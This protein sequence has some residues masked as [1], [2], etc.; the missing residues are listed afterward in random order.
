MK[1]TQPFLIIFSGLL[2][3]YS[4]YQI[5]NNFMQSNMFI[6]ILASILFGTICL[7]EYRSY[8]KKRKIRNQQLA[9]EQH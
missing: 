2:A 7:I 6:H 3:L 5:V 1:R 9:Q 8:K 4:I